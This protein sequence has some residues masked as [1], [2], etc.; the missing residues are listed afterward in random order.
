[1]RTIYLSIVIIFVT[2]I[3]ILATT[4]STVGIKTKKFNNLISSK[5]NQSNNHV[6]LKLETIR[7][8]INI[9]EVSLFL[10]TSNSIVSYR[11]AIIPTK[12]LKIYVDFLSIIK[13]ETKIKK[14]SLILD[15]LEIKE[16]KKISNLLK[17]S[18]FTS[19]IN[20]KIIG[21]ELKAE[22]E[23]YLNQNNQID[24]FITKGSVLNLQTKINKDLILNKTNFDFFADKSDILL[25]NIFGE[26]NFIKILEGDLKANFSSEIELV[27]NFKTNFNYIFDSKNTP[28]ILQNFKFFKNI[29]NINAKLTN[30]LILKFDKTY[31][32]KDFEYINNGKISKLNFYPNNPIKNYLLPEDIDNLSIRNSEIKSRFTK[33]IN[34]IELLGQYSINKKNFLN[35]NLEH[36]LKKTVSQFNLNADYDNEID[37]KIINYKKSKDDIAKISLNL[38]KNKNILKI[39]KLTL[40][41]N[42]NFI[43]IKDMKLDKQK[44]SSLG[45]MKVKTTLNNK[46]NNNFEIKYGKKIDIIGS[47]FDASNL[48]EILNNQTGSNLFNNLNKDIEIDFK[49]IIAPLSEEIKSFKLIGKIKKG[50]FTKITSKGSFGK[51]S[52]IDI[53]MIDDEKN[54][55]KY[56]EVYSDIAMPLLT[57]FSFFNGLSGG[58]LFY[59]SLIGEKLISS[60]LQ[61]ENFKVINAPGLVKLLSLAD[62]GGLADLTRGEGLSFDLLEISMEK[63]GKTLNIN[64]IL[65]IGPSVS[66]L[67]EGYQNPTVTSLRGT[68]V[69]AKTFNQL[70][71]KIPV[72]GEII[73]PKEVGEGLFGIS[74]KMKGPPGKIKTTINPIRT[75]TPR[76][77]QKILDKNKKSK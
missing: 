60:K 3:I 44:F 58:K 31:K 50:K 6:N 67:M 49:N 1:M 27:S 2:T 59:T 75:I 12:S 77:I 8:K 64:E 39:N 40:S 21:G 61:I 42:E 70:I 30:N 71:S 55:K 51:N 62:L 74:F 32:L 48:P 53:S 23:V 24:N 25:K 26:L 68:L 22:I 34:A 33:N 11:D 63:S 14:V 65:A 20:N 72:I 17:P 46:I 35:F 54:R 47:K 76:F 36:S 7:F 28:S 66:I 13:N 43:L 4:L 9:K 18:N 16:L 10:E 56:L 52:F 19:I 69:P 57:E 41:E 29:E 73:I 37:L 45:Q 38:E 15:Q 5:I